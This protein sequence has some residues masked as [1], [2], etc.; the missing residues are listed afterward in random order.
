MKKQFFFFFLL[1][2]DSKDKG[3]SRD[4]IKFAKKLSLLTIKMWRCS[5]SSLSSLRANSGMTDEAV[6]AVC[7]QVSA[8]GLCSEAM[9]G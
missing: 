9:A 4:G 8:D 1:W 7:Y 3:Y 5:Y 2:K 6:V